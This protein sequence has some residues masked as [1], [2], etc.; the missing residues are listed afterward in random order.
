VRTMVDAG[1]VF[2]RFLANLHQSCVSMFQVT[3]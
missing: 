1:Q 3:T 2:E